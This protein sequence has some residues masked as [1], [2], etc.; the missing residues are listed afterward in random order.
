MFFVEAYDTVAD[1]GAHRDS[2]LH[3]LVLG[4]EDSD[5]L[6][7][8]SALFEPGTLLACGVLGELRSGSFHDEGASVEGAEGKG[9]E[10]AGEGLDRLIRVE[11]YFCHNKSVFLGLVICRIVSG[12]MDNVCHAATGRNYATEVDND[13]SQPKEGEV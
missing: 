1:L 4:L 2:D 7:D 3:V 8:D 9:S 12:V 11:S 6:V 5:A 10:R 13:F